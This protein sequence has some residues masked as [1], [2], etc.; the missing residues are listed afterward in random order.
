M[1]H[2]RCSVG[3]IVPPQSGAKGLPAAAAGGGLSAANPAPAKDAKVAGW[4]LTANKTANLTDAGGQT[5]PILESEG[6]RSNLGGCRWTVVDVSPAVFKTAGGALGNPSSV[7]DGYQPRRERGEPMLRKRDDYR[8]RD[9]G[10]AS[11][12][13]RRGSSA[14]IAGGA[15]V[16]NGCTN[17]ND[18]AALRGVA[19][20]D[21]YCGGDNGN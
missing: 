17:V 15:H 1:N 2:S 10:S 21:W 14:P 13:R 12:L 3:R 20:V 4:S 5:R 6:A 16:V 7:R 11:H 9:L 8:Y 18:L 19:V